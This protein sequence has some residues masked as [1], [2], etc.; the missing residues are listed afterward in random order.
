VAYDII[1]DI[2]GHA[3]KLTALLTALGYVRRSGVWRHPGRQAVFIGDLIDRGTG[4]VETLRIV[5]DMVEAGAARAIMGNHEFNAIGYNVRHPD[6]HDEYLRPRSDKNREQHEAFTAQVGE[7]SDDHA[8]WVDWFLTLPLWLDLGGVRVVHACWHP[9]AI[10][11]VTQRLGGNL[12]TREAV[13]EAF[14]RGA[15]NSFA[16]DGTAPSGGSAL[17]HAIETLL[18]GVEVDLP[19]G[20]TFRDKGGHVRR[21]ARTRWWA[22]SPATFRTATLSTE[23]VIDQLPDLELPAVVVPGHDGGSPILVGHYWMRGTPDRQTA[24]IACVDYSAGKGGPLV[25]YRWD[26]EDE[27]DSGKF[28]AAGA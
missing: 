13:P 26:G 5:R 16:Y 19:P 14:A 23:D 18:K 9:D 12:L 10:A 1:G 25:A 11:A 24:K 4:Q 2:H 20:V 28:V 8:E 27:L 22:G 21:N 17:D 7:D 3:D 6:R 15:R